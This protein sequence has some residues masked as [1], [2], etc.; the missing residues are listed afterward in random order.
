MS[1]PDPHK[2]FGV[3]L[4][5]EIFSASSAMNTTKVSARAGGNSPW[6]TFSMKKKEEALCRIA[7]SIPAMLVENQNR[8]LKRSKK[9]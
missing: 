6:V 8:N 4:T 5:Q 7:D 2:S 3:V 9:M 1:K